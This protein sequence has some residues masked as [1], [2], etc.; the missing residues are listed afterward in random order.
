MISETSEVGKRPV[1]HVL[2]YTHWDREFRFDFETTRS[3]LVQLMDRLVRILENDP[4]FGHFTLDGQFILVDD[5]LEIRPEMRERLQRLAREGRI[6]TGPWYSLPDSSAIHGEALL[7]NLAT[8]RHRAR[9]F[10]G[11]MD[12]GYNVFSFGQISQLPQIY[13]GFGID[14]I[15]FYKHMD[16]SRTRHSEFIWEGPDGTRMLATRLGTEA[17]WNYFMLGHVP[18]VFGQD[19]AHRDWQYIWGGL[20]KTFHMAEAA[21]YADFHFVTEPLGG[22]D[23]GR[24]LEGI[25]RTV[26]SLGGTAVPEHLLF[27]DGIDFTE[28]NPDIPKILEVARRECEGRYEIRHGGLRAYVEAVKPL[29]RQRDL[30][31]AY[32]EM[33]DGPVGSVHTDVCSTH[34]RLKKLNGLVENALFRQ[35][36]PLATLAWLHGA[37]YPASYIARVLGFMFRNHAHDS[38]HG[39]GPGSMIADLENRHLQACVVAENTAKQAMRDLSVKINT[40]SITASDILLTVF[41][42]SPWMR[43]EVL[44]AVIDLPARTVVDRLYIETEGGRRVSAHVLDRREAR[45]G[46][47]H[48]RGR[49]MPMYC[50]RFEVLFEADSIPGLGYRTFAVTWEEKRE[51]PYPHEGFSNPRLPARPLATSPRSAENEFLA[52]AIN[53][54]GTFDLHDKETGRTYSRL[55]SFVDNGD[56]GNLDVFIAPEHDTVISSLGGSAETGLEISSHLM[57]KFNVNLVLEIPAM[58]DFST[59]RRSSARVGIP[60]QYSIILRKGSRIV[61]TECTLDNRA[62]D[63]FLRLVFPSGLQAGKVQAGAPF[64]TLEFPTETVCEGEWSTTGLVRHQQ[65]LFMNI[66][67]G[68]AGLAI[69]NDTLRDFEVIDPQNGV[70]AQSLVRSIPL[71]IPVDNRLWMQYPNDESGQ[72]P[73]LLT[74]RTGLMPHA[75]SW[76]SAG[77]ARAAQNFATR[78]RLVQLGSQSG[79]CPSVLGGIEIDNPNVQF[80]CFKRSEDGAMAILRLWNPCE[81]EQRVVVDLRKNAVRVC[82]LDFNEECLEEIGHHTGKIELMIGKKKIVSLGIAPEGIW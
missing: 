65:H 7:R 10:G 36:E 5:Y 41:N 81:S 2:S 56:V 11:L 23:A 13:S 26:A 55:Y 62:K 40:S 72:S 33:K 15:V 9:E 4:A 77:I 73:G 18:A 30:D 8:G 78:L 52:L 34:P 47:Y 16:P 79:D 76:N 59:G 17:R 82:L 32:G 3:W 38:L 51:Y 25:E 70:I 48:P 14:F 19:P 53:G 27:W 58:M 49:N 50:E 54:D 80:S 67:E 35:A 45:A 63:H 37:E 69:L 71:S 28:A 21:D 68:N 60:I 44:T 42:P 24:V 43:S 12:I 66:E 74:L 6:S 22:F 31:T 61:E 1:I 57:A 39:I 75:G 64:D 20:G 46:I 29:L